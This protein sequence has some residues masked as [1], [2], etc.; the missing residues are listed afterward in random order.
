NNVHLHAC[1]G[2]GAVV[3]Y[4]HDTDLLE[5]NQYSLVMKYLEQI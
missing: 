1:M 2:I 3:K 5:K 4:L